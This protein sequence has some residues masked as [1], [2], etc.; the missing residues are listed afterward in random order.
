MSDEII[1]E[2]HAIKDAIGAQFNYDLR[3]LF[4]DIKRCE[5]E[6]QDKGVRVITPPTD[7]ARMESTALQRMRFARRQA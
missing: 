6:L 5:A 1:A 4:V 3:A 2:L 7:P